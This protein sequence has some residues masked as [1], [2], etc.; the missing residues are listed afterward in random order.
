MTQNIQKFH[1]NASLVA[2]YFKHRCDRLFRWN[3]VE[4]RLHQKPGIGWGIPAKKKSSSRPGIQLLMGAGDTFELD[5][6]L[7]LREEGAAAGA[8][9]SEHVLMGEITQQ[10]L[11]TL[12][13]PVEFETFRQALQRP[14]PPRYTAQLKISLSELPDVEHSFLTRFGLA[15]ERVRVGE[16]RPD[17]IETVYPVI[18]GEPILLRIWDFKASQKARHEHFIQVAYYS[19]LLEHLLAASNLDAFKVD[20]HQGVIF[21]REGKKEFDLDPYR[22]AVEDFLRNRVLRI[23]STRADEVHFH[24]CERC[25]MCEY[26]DHCQAEADA[27]NDLSRVAYISSD[28]KRALSKI[29]ILTHRELARVSDITQIESLRILSHDLSVNLTRYL[30]TAQ[31]LEDG[32]PRSLEST[33]L[34][35][36]RWDDIRIILSAESDPVTA[37]CFAIGMKTY[38]GWDEQVRHPL[39]SEYTFVAESKG[40]EV[41]VLLPFLQTLN[42]LLRQV[43]EENR[44]I[45]FDQDPAYQQALAASET[46]KAAFDQHYAE[47]GRKRKDGLAERYAALAAAR[48][49]AKRAL[50][51]VEKQAKWQ[52][53]TK[54]KKLHFYVYDSLDLNILKQA[55]ERH[56]FDTEHPELLAEISHLVRLFPPESVLPDSDSFRSMP[57][58]VVIQVLR[59]LVALPIPYL[60]SLKEVSKSYQPTNP[61]GQEKGYKYLPKYGFGWEHSNQVAFERIHDVWNNEGFRYDSRDPSK[62][63]QPLQILEMIRKTILDK[64]RATDTIVRKLKNDHGEQLRLRK[65]PFRLYDGFNPLDFQ[66]LEAMRTFTMLETSIAELNVKQYHS[67]PVGD[68]AAKFECIRG[69]QY[70]DGQDEVDGSLWFTFDPASRDAKF[71]AGDFNLVLTPEDEPAHLLAEVDGQLFDTSRWR[72]EPYKVTLVRYELSNNPPRVL[73]KP[74]NPEKLRE[75]VDITKTCALDKLFADYTT[76]R[77]FQVLERL[78][79]NR[80]QAVHVHSLLDSMQVPGWQPFVDRV[81]TLKVDLK[82]QVASA[83]EEV[84]TLLNDAQWKAWEGV[85]LEPLTMIWG[86]PGTGKTYTIAQ[87]LLGYALHARRSGQ[88]VRILVTA[89]THHAIVNVLRSAAK[90]AEKYGIPEENLKLIKVT[91]SAPHTADQDLPERVRKAGEEAIVQQAADI[92]LGCVILG[93]TVW[94]A[95]KAM[96]QAGGAVQPWFDVILVDEASQMKLPDALIA[97]SASKPNANIILAGDDKQLPPIIMGKYPDQH[98]YMLSSV[99]AFMRSRMEARLDDDPG[100]E[101][102]VLFQLEENFRMNEPLTAY[103]RQVLYRNRF[104]SKWPAI[105]IAITSPV[106]TPRADLVEFLLNPE[107]PVL[108]CWYEP[109]RSFTAR[110]P[111]EAEIICDLMVRLG[112]VLQHPKQSR[113]YTPAEFAEQG[114]AALS[115]HRAQNST[116]RNVLRSCGFGTEER[117]LPLVD[118]VDKLQGQERDVVLV[119]YGVADGEYAEAEAEFLLSSNRFNVAATRARHK[120]IVFASSTVLDVVPNDQKVLLDSMMLKEFRTYC[121]DGHQQFSYKSTEFGEIPMHVQWKGF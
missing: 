74:E 96:D 70:Q 64:L 115:P 42:A 63:M 95:A 106:A 97:F 80:D 20:T 94:A 60:Y 22:L 55:I 119:S 35:M 86:P 110:N 1:L 72:H 85:F 103:P 121:C 91:G 27:A 56:L 19:F 25:A 69:L 65:E 90:W 2:A 23:L 68:R 59:A 38:E 54:Q 118:T 83:G 71:D 30:A 34:L 58:T 31:A 76:R 46:A 84:E 73:L 43:D 117:P 113:M 5:N 101:E 99:F 77:V 87:I 6:I 78:N 11:R 40:D 102:R 47:H 21:S 52:A 4:S 3:A 51:E 36:P 107:L 89:F 39:G 104:S 53:F 10:G 109:P 45:S 17:L 44:G 8:A 26:M 33:T 61:D 75:R 50:K 66:M 37:T 15:P 14:I 7:R 100:F 29:G 28:S 18:S 13:V 98:E 16:T 93:A 79:A 48:D 81:D 62:I 108:L 82:R 120:L 32:L 67:L 12:V 116:I 41:G 92:E 105:R 24:V 88:P 114:V 112:G 9:G 57:G 111:I 49:E